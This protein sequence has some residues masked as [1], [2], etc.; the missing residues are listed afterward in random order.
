MILVEQVLINSWHEIL[1]CTV[2]KIRSTKASIMPS[3][4]QKSPNEPLNDADEGKEEENNDAQSLTLFEAE[5]ELL[6]EEREDTALSLL[7]IDN[8]P[9]TRDSIR[10]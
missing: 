2:A 5:E 4:M 3:Q 10:L 8:D 9:H 7:D 1:D 6:A